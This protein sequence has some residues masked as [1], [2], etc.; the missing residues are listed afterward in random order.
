MCVRARAGA[1]GQMWG[2]LVTA[3]CTGVYRLGEAAPAFGSA[4]MRLG[5]R[6]SGCAGA[7]CGVGGGRK[8]CV[9]TRQEC[10]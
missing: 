9:S 10:V 2:Y 6:R 5:A 3:A 1:L 4:G 8:S 7:V